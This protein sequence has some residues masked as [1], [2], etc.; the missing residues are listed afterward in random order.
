MALTTENVKEPQKMQLRKLI[1][2]SFAQKDCFTLIKP[3]I[4]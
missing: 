2:E 3:L 4:D 1:T